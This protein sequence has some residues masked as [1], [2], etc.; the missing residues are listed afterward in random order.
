MKKNYFKYIIGVLIVFSFF[1]ITNVSFCATA[2]AD[3]TVCFIKPDSWDGTKLK[4]T[5]LNDQN[6]TL[7]ITPEEGVLKKISNISYINTTLGDFNGDIYNFKIPNLEDKT[8]TKLK[9]STSDESNTSTTLEYQ[10]S[11]AYKIS[12]GSDNNQTLSTFEVKIALG[13]ELQKIKADIIKYNPDCSTSVMD[14]LDTIIQDVQK[15]VVNITSNIWDK[16]FTP[17]SSF[18]TYFEKDTESLDKLNSTIQKAKSTLE[19]GGYD[20]NSTK[21]L[22][23]NITKAESAVENSSVFTND[24]IKELTKQLETSISNLVVDTSTLESLL[25]QAKDIMD[26]SDYFTDDSIKNL[27]DTISN[28]Q[29]GINDKE[30][31]TVDKVKEL[32]NSLKDLIEKAEYDL[33]ALN[34]LIKKAES[35]DVSNY[36]DDSVQVLKD[37]LTKAKS[38]NE[39]SDLSIQDYI[40]TVS[41]LK[42]ALDGL[43]QKQVTPNNTATSNPST[44]DILYIIIPIIVLALVVI[45]FTFVYSKKKKNN[46]I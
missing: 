38:I 10:P 31:L 9:F 37:A 29:E 4:L 25:L 1:F 21:A 7:D 26:F 42:T 8:Y 17:L 5:L 34:E 44:G 23:E 36:T 46:N 2:N 35:I 32:T 24:Q 18:L 14:N 12:S 39:T 27:P 15:Y 45:G 13:V 6:D 11:K 22:Q 19:P 41:N 30:N 28:A 33:S 3:E 16:I 40:S 43:S 20:D